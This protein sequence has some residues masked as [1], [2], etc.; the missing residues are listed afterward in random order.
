MSQTNRRRLLLAAGNLLLDEFGH[1]AVGLLGD[2][3]DILH[4]GGGLVAF[5]FGKLREQVGQQG[6]EGADIPGGQKGLELRRGLFHAGTG[7]LHVQLQ[8]LAGAVKSRGGH[9]VGGLEGFSLGLHQLIDGR[10][11]G[12][13][14]YRVRQAATPA[15]TRCSH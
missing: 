2:V 8:Q 15:R 3:V 1:L 12:D 10:K 9:G 14:R 6:V 11:H 7:R 5:R 13:L 4:V